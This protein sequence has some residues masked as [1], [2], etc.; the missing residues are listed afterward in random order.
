M[1][2]K[3]CSKMHSTHEKNPCHIPHEFISMYCRTPSQISICRNYILWENAKQVLNTKGSTYTAAMC[4][5]QRWSLL[6]HMLKCVPLLSEH[7]WPTYFK[8]PPKSCC[9]QD[10]QRQNYGAFESNPSQTQMIDFPC[11]STCSPKPISPKPAV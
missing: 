11:P 2:R 1:P 6:W 7:T 9:R 5:S 8:L 10:W 4:G 3:P